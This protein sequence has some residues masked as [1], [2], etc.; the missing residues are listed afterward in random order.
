MGSETTTKAGRLRGRQASGGP[1]VFLGVPYAQPPLG[2]LRFRAPVPVTPWQGVR[3][4]AEYGPTAPQPEQDFTLIPEPVVRG[5]D[6]LNLNIYTPDL[7]SA[8]LPV[9]VWIHGGGFFSGCNRSPWYRGESFARDG[10]V[11]VSI[12]Y[13][14]GAEGFLALEGA[15]PNRGV[16]DWMAALQWVQDNISAFGGDPSRVT[17]AGQS[18]GGAACA[19]LLGARRARGLFSQAILMS[20][21]AHMSVSPLAAQQT[22]AAFAGELGTEPTRTAFARI[23][24]EDLVAVQQRQAGAGL[25]GGG[26]VGTA[27][28]IAAN[29]LTLGPSPDG[30]LLAATPI[31]AIAAG[32]GA[33]VPVLVGNTSQEFTM[34]A[35]LAGGEITEAILLEALAALGLTDEK[36]RQYLSEG[37]RQPPAA[38]FAQAITDRTFRVPAVRVAEARANAVADTCLYEFRWQA[39]GLGGLLGAGHCTDLPFVFDLLGAEGVAAVAGDEP[40]QELADVMHRAWVQFISTGAPGWSAYE[41]TRRATMLFGSACEVADDPA[42]SLRSIWDGV[43]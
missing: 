17:I 33:D 14:L 6:F 25:A 26:P 7:G 2:E 22:A 1:H 13:R 21:A 23:G 5:D 30:D 41:K 28:R 20:G 43:L 15:P 38:L 34:M 39:P 11:L 32:A 3:E 29:L 16:L 10:V 12:N 40:P 37:G 35:G 24:V 8:G 9:L 42:Q 36:A 18:A 19:T 27:R 31:E 4:A